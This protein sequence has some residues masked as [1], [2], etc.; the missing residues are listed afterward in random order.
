MKVK[1][2][3]SETAATPTQGITTPYTAAEGVSGV[4]KEVKGAQ[5]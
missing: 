1:P 4:L 3:A 5:E 2:G